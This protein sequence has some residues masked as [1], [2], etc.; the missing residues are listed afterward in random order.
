MIKPLLNK[1]ESKLLTK[2]FMRWVE[3]EYD[4]ET[5]EMTKAMIHNRETEL[6]Y[7]VDKINH[8]EIV[9]FKRYD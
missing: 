6:K 1:L 4:I 9:G 7:L 3:T 8:K 5:L 2:L